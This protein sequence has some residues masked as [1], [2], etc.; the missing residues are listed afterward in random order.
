MLLPP[1]PTWY[2]ESS[3][4]LS[5]TCTC[6]AQLASSL[7]PVLSNCRHVMSARSYRYD[8]ATVSCSLPC[9]APAPA[10]L[11]A[12]RC[13]LG[14]HFANILMNLCNRF[15]SSFFSFC[16]SVLHVFYLL[17]PAAGIMIALAAVAV[18][19]CGYVSFLS[20]FLFLLLLLSSVCYA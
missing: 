13:L 19:V 6:P 7:R 20:F 18:A 3:A 5:C 16:P 12:R 4:A 8:F 10:P 11:C 15:F 1:I 14:I 2:I 17:S 9:P